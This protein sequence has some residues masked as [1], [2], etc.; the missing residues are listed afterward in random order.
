M[1][2]TNHATSVLVTVIHLYLH[3]EV[4]LANI[5]ICS[6]AEIHDIITITE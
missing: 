3:G 1:F 4:T 2:L 6:A 5:T